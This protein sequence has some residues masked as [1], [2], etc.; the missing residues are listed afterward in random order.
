MKLNK[1][2]EDHSQTT[3]RDRIV[4]AAR[5]LFAER[6]FEGVTLRLIGQEVGLHNSSLMHHF[7]NK[8][9]IIAEALAQVAD[10]QLAFLSPLG[11]DDPPSLDRFV[12]VML[13]YS[14]QL[15]RDRD[16]ARV[17]MRVLLNPEHFLDT[18]VQLEKSLPGNPRNRLTPFMQL[19]INWLR[20]ASDAGVIRP[21]APYQAARLVLG[22]LLLEP[23]WMTA[24][25]VADRSKRKRREELEAFLRGALQPI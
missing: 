10:E 9:E 12:E 2:E 13:R 6:G 17:D 4:A 8:R 14:D 19:L 11:S 7:G 3:A 23:I 18:Q 21:V 5:R 16:M 20:R 24:A 15:A 25:Q 1:L 22:L